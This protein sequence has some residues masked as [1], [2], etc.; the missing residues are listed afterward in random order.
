MHSPSAAQVETTEAEFMYQLE[1]GAPDPD[2]EL[3]GIAVER[4]AGGVV[5]S[6]HNDPTSYWSKALG[7][8]FGEPVTEGLI[9]RVLD[10]WRDQQNPIGVL[11][12]APEVTPHNWNQIR[13]SRGLQPAGRIAKMAAPIGDVVTTGVSDLRIAPVERQD[14]ERWA[15]VVLDGLGMPHD[16][17]GGMFAAMVSHPRFYPYA[18]WDGDTIAGGG[19]LFVHDD[20][21][22]IVAGAVL[23][24]YR[25][26]GAQTA[27]I[28]AR[29]AKAR[30]LG[31]RWL[32]GETGQ[33][34]EG[35]SN[36]SMNNMI[37]AGLKPLYV[38]QNHTWRPA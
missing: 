36:S 28:G 19:T 33:P 6:A 16:G 24:P 32:I 29:A 38:R 17:L 30:A 9:D 12:I 26:R 15:R 35:R 8:G 3:L 14:A 13:E 7:F 27:L 31:C 2:Q 34:A 20:I 21:G 10:V 1:A 22:E 11:Q 25:N 18:A 5:L 37:R 4:L 23:E